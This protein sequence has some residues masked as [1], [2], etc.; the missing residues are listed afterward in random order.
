MKENVTQKRMA[1]GLKELSESLGLSVGF[2]RKQ[3]KA[4]SLPAK[5]LGRRVVVLDHHL[6]SYLASEPVENSM[7]L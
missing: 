7:K 4:G 1:W 6:R 3:V 5:R 2:L